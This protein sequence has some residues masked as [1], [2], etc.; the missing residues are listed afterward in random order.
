MGKRF[1][2]CLVLIIAVLCVGVVAVSVSIA[3]SS[4]SSQNITV[5][6]DLVAMSEDAYR[7]TNASLSAFSLEIQPAANNLSTLTPKDANAKTILLDLYELHPEAAGVAWVDASGTTITYPMFSLPRILESSVLKNITEDSFAENEIL[8][9]GPVYSNAYGMVLCLL[10]PVYTADGIYNGYLC[11]AQSPNVLINGTPGTPF[12][13]NTTYEL[14]IG[15]SEGD[16][17]YHPDATYIATNYYTSPV[18]QRQDKLLSGL[19]RVFAEP[20][21]TASYMFYPLNGDNLLEKTII[22]KTLSFG[23]QDLRLVLSDY[24]SDPI[25]VIYPENPNLDKMVSDVQQ[26]FLYAKRHGQAETL[27]AMNNPNGR[28][29]DENYE[30][31]AYSMDGTVLSM[32]DMAYLVGQNVINYKGAWGLNIVQNMINRALQGG[33]YLHYYDML[34]YSDN[35]A[36][37]NIAYLLPVDD[38]WFIGAR[39]PLLNHTVTYDVQ[40]R[41]DLINSVQ[42]VQR[43]IAEYGKDQTLVMITA[44]SNELTPPAGKGHVFAVDYN[45]ILLADEI[46]TDLIGKDIF[47]I[48]DSRG[49]SFVREIVMVAKGGGGYV[50]TETKD[51][52]TGLMFM[53]LMYVE[54]VDDEWCVVSVLFLNSFDVTEGAGSYE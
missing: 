1:V 37:F 40:K 20:E 5:S 50:L 7:S 28:F 33:G 17:L 38:T 53:T 41:L 21:G 31:F 45:G 3:Y 30:I 22:W 29:A 47:Y 54:P 12:Y 16:I 8:L 10:V 52:A 19:G 23:G 35:Q 48:T 34:L 26:M 18:Y 44:P 43:Y 32:P 6:D 24:P 51:D 13:K 25:E 15:N 4:P 11:V 9:V 14:W 42:T 27:A 39:M 49:S 46:N 2:I 36:I